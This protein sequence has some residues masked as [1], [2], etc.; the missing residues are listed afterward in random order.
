MVRATVDEWVQAP[1]ADQLASAASIAAF[2]FDFED[3]YAW[4]AA[5]SAI[6]GCINEMA[7]S[8]ETVEYAGHQEL[9]DL[10]GLCAV[11]LL[12]QERRGVLSKGALDETTR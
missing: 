12:D 3:E 10:A 5:A 9:S 4:I 8:E 11:F 2:A 7:L 6:Q 1:A